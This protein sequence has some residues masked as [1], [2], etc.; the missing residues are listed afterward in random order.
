MQVHK[1][2]A[3]NGRLCAVVHV[4]GLNSTQMDYE[5]R[6]RHGRLV[7]ELHVERVDPAQVLKGH[8]CDCRNAS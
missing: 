4:K 3:H 2:R 7:A 6:I 1:D 5:C 8:I